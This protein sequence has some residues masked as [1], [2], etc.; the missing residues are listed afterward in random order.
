MTGRQNFIL[1]L[2]VLAT[3]LGGAYVY[4]HDY[5]DPRATLVLPLDEQ[6]DLQRQACTRTLP[7][8][9]EITFSIEPRP[10]PLITPLK[11]QVKVKGIEAQR[12]EVDFAGVSMKMGY[13]RPRLEAVAAGLFS[14]EGLLPV[15]I[16]QR[17]DWEAQVILHTPGNTISVPYRFVT[18][19]E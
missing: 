17:M 11:L 14:G 1:P 2:L 8:G 13:N 7:G 12:V 4:F 9:G 6:C 5:F 15:C 19:R 18:I 10:I 16:R 3:L